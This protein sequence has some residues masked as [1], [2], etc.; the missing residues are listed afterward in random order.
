MNAL[1][2]AWTAWVTFWATQ[3]H[4][5]SLALVRILLG[6]VILYD[7]VQIW[8]LDLVTPLFAPAEVGGLSGAANR[9]NPPLW[10][11]VFPPSVASAKLLH[12]VI[13]VSAVAFTFG[14]FT[15]TAAVVLLFSWAQHA[16][17]MPAAD[18]G[19]DTLCRDVLWIFVFADAGA[20]WSVDALRRTGSWFGDGAPVGAWAR[21][22]VILQ[23]VAM[24]FLA[25]VQKGGIH[26]YPMGH[27]AALYFILQD[28]AIAQYDFT[29]LGRQPF[30][31]STQLGT[32]VTIVFQD[33]YPL[34]LLWAHYRNTPDRPGKLR[35]FANRW[36][37]EWWWIATGALFHVLLA[38]TTELGIF[39][40]A[41]LAL[42][43]AWLRP[44]D[45]ANLQQ[46]VAD[47]TGWPVAPTG[48]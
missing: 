30:F 8:Q 18:R 38:A 45:L 34:V 1:K 13:T 7:F 24:Y 9:A 17:I 25:G 19:I 20:T 6:L 16:M 31:F 12:V 33:S 36:G 41:M 39:P 15:R 22:L 10:Y 4:P 32:A 23:L 35:A 11:T 46:W 43:P 14:A 21:R 28:P 44:V 37:L 40:W 42:Y 48:A 29:F 27:F 5:R 3:E 26:W 47:R 2:R